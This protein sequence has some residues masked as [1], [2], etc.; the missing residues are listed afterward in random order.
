LV[1]D[2]ARLTPAHRISPSTEIFWP[3]IIPPFSFE[4]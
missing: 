1:R 3:A 4:I 2:E